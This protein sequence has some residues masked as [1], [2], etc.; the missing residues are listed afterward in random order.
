MVEEA[1]GC[2]RCLRLTILELVEGLDQGSG[3]LLGC[4][5][6][7]LLLPYLAQEAS[8]ARLIHVFILDHVMVFAW[9]D[10]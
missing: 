5:V 7:T 9:L 8:L 2:E 6:T 4:M 3:I 10:Y 1:L